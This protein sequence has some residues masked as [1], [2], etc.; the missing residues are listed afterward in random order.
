MMMRQTTD[1][2]TDRQTNGQNHGGGG[3]DDFFLNEI[4][5]VCRSFARSPPPPRPLCDTSLVETRNR[6]YCL[7]SPRR[8]PDRRTC[9]VQP[10]L[11]ELFLRGHVGPVF[12]FLSGDQD[13]WDL[14]AVAG[15][16]P[17]S[18]LGRI[19]TY[20][21]SNFFS[22]SRIAATSIHHGTIALFFS[23]EISPAQLTVLSA[24]CGVRNGLFKFK[25]KFILLPSLE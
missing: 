25:F 6:N 11:R 7:K 13:L 8:T 19:V 4:S 9:T 22:T 18:P 24:P 23:L 2:Q 12:F 1:R 3:S 17:R 5:L 16:G 14:A 21:T 10:I 20:S 15:C